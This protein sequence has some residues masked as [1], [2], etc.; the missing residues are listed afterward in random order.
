[1]EWLLKILDY[2]ITPISKWLIKQLKKP[3]PVSVLK[4]RENLRKEFIKNIATSDQYSSE[5]IIRNIKKLDEYPETTYDKKKRDF[6][7]F[8]SRIQRFIS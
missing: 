1:M 8:Q 3:E 5:L 7:L 6:Y 2:T 4:R